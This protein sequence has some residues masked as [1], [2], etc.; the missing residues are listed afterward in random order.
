MKIDVTRFC[1]LSRREDFQNWLKSI[2]SEHYEELMSFLKLGKSC[3]DN[4]NKMEK[5]YEKLINENR[6]NLMISFLSKNYPHMLI[7]DNKDVHKKEKIDIKKVK[8]P[9]NLSMEDLNFHKVFQRYMPGLM[10]I[11]HQMIFID[12]DRHSLEGRITEFTRMKVQTDYLILQ[13]P[14]F[15]HGYIEYFERKFATEAS[16][17]QNKNR[18]IFVY[19]RKNNLR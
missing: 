7:Y 14:V 1:G 13:G 12:N 11:P 2:S 19:K 10:L 8:R 3:G 18:P 4:K 17:F 15:F 9:V 6:S 16:K 5:I